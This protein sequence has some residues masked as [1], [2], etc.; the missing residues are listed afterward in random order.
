M[1]NDSTNQ[2]YRRRKCPRQTQ[3]GN[4]QNFSS[5]FKLPF[6]QAPGQEEGRNF[7]RPPR[8]GTLGGSTAD[9]NTFIIKSEDMIEKL[10]NRIVSLFRRER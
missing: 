4:N 5:A 6:S 8:V 1:T 9:Y 7:R 3:I 2:F 10:F